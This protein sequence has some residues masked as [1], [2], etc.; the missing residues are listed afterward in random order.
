[1]NKKELSVIESSVLSMIPRGTGKKVTLNDI[2]QLTSLNLREVQS[3]ISSL[4]FKYKI[5][6]VANRGLGGIFIPLTNEQRSQGLNGIKNQVI[7]LNKRI[8]IVESADLIDW[9]KNINLSYQE[10]LEV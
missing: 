7:D 6:I 3:V 1:M 2:C 10:R 5:P 8:E 4:V 9:N